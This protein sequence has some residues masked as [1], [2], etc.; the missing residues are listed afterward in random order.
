ME[1]D[2]VALKLLDLGL[3]IHLASSK[4]DDSNSMDPILSELLNKTVENNYLLKETLGHVFLKDK[5][6]LKTYDDTTAIIVIE[7]MAKSFV[8]GKLSI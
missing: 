7:N 5:S 6:R 3:R 1:V 4:N 8:D 2:L